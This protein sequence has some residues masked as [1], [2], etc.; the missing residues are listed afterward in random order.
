MKIVKAKVI[1]LESDDGLVKFDSYIGKEY[2]VD[3]DEVVDVELISIE[4]ET[5]HKKKMVL[6]VQ[7]GYIPVELL[8]FGEEVKLADFIQDKIYDFILNYLDQD[9]MSKT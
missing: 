2:I 9:E 5:K 4:K 3:V 1:K 6:D 8:E 7:G